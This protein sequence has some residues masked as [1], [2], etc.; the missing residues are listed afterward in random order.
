MLFGARFLFWPRVLS[1]FS[2][3]FSFSWQQLQL[4][5]ASGG[6]RQPPPFFL[7]TAIHQLYDAF[8]PK[9]FAFLSSTNELNNLTS[10][11]LRFGIWLISYHISCQK[12]RENP[13]K[14]PKK[15]SQNQAENQSKCVESPHYKKQREIRTFWQNFNRL[16]LRAKK[17]FLIQIKKITYL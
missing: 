1:S 7:D 17:R 15:V 10:L 4:A 12:S 14:P 5:E 2:W 9:W 11:I 3:H 16:V 8:G 6:V 13:E